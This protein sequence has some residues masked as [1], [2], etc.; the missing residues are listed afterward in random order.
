[1]RADLVQELLRCPRCRYERHLSWTTREIRRLERRR[2][3]LEGV[4]GSE[5]VIAIIDERIAKIRDREV[6]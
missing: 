2:R 1:M 6:L 5:E 4:R 3:D